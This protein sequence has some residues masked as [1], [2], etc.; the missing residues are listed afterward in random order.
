MDERRLED[1][2]GTEAAETSSAPARPGPAAA[3]TGAADT[4][5]AAAGAADAGAADA[6]AAPDEMSEA[7]AGRWP[8]TRDGSPGAWQLHEPYSGWAAQPRAPGPAA[9]VGYAEFGLRLAG[10]SIDLALV[11][12]GT[13]IVAN[14]VLPAIREL[15]GGSNASS[16]EPEM[17]GI[18]LIGVLLL[19]AAAYSVTVLRGTPGQLAMGLATLGGGR[20]AR[21]PGI[22]AL[23]RELLLF[24]PAFVVPLLSVIVSYFVTD[25][26]LAAALTTWLPIAFLAWYL[27]L[28]IIALASPRGQ[29]L[30]D[31]LV[32]SVVIREVS[33][34]DREDED[35]DEDAEG[36][37]AGAA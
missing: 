13:S 15:M 2:P 10:F 32:G 16:G 23:V 35:E 26:D 9:G 37:L 29:G 25:Q 8:A 6:E 3:D 7:A 18:A 20:G 34:D 24:G 14:F 12:V 17:V 36:D 22:V 31:L 21:L 30:H 11:W 4:E 33:E 19:L 1:E 28:A 27:L 5:A